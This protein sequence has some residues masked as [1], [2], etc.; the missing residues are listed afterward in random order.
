MT[1]RIAIHGLGY[2]G[3]TAAVHWARAGWKVLGY[4][5]DPA[6]VA[7]FNSGTPRAG[8]F[9]EYLD[10]DVRELLA[11]GL[12]EATSDFDR[13]LEIR[14]HSIAVPTER[15]G[16]P[17]NEIVTDLVERLLCR[18]L[19]NGEPVDILVESTLTPGT[20]DAVL[21][22]CALSPEGGLGA[23][24][25]A[26]CPRRDWFAGKDSHLGAMKR[27][28]GGVT[29]AC[30][31][32]AVELLSNVSIDIE[33]T[34]YRTAEITKSLENA[35]LHAAVMLPSEL[36]M[37]MRDRDVAEA[38]RLATTHPRLMPLYLGAGA[39]G[40]CIPIAPR[41]LNALHGPH[42]LLSTALIIDDNIRHAAAQAVVQR[43]CKSA[44]VLGMGYR[45]DFKD[46]G[47]SPGLAVAKHLRAA[48]LEVHV[49]DPMWSP[50]ELAEL[51]GL[52]D[53]RRE[54]ACVYEA[55]LEPID[56]VVL[57]TPHSL[58]E[59]SWAVMGNGG[60]KFILDAQGTWK[61][62]AVDF[63]SRGIEYKQIGQAGWLK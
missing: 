10:A 31:A 9:L 24:T 49:H 17:Y 3:L 43:G 39:G 35:L 7:R 46:M 4:D 30:T 28:V 41:Y 62:Y 20:I 32:R 14:V 33:P 8:E 27:I 34:T 61:K 25:L 55:D 5:P 19:T 15:H 63:A 11:E 52:P 48:G 22:T 23:K 6:T 42:A 13:T 36:A 56:A 16:E 51:T 40:R 37:N 59:G 2:V 44:L 50:A 29:P 53:M 26:V 21:E 45:P 54:D 1:D 58:Y 60:R 57:A 12:L 18:L 47:L 38:L